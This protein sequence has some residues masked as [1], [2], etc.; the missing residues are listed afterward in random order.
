MN[1]FENQW[2]EVFRAGK[3]TDSL[4]R[5]HEFTSKDL[6][7]IVNSYDN[8]NHEAPV[9]IG[10]PKDNAPAFGWV[11]ELKTDGKTLFAKFKQLVPEFVDAVKQGLYKKRSI[12]LYPNLTLRHIGFLG[13][14]PPAVKGLAD[15]AFHENG[16]DIEFNEEKGEESMNLEGL[17]KEFEEKFGT[18]QKSNETL[19]EQN[20]EFSTKLEEVTKSNTDLVAKNEELAKKVQEFED[21]KN[22]KEGGEESEE[23]KKTNKKFNEELEKRD[24]QINEIKAQLETEKAENRKKEYTE[25]ANGLVEQGKAVADSV[26]N[27]ISI[28]VASE[29]AGTFSFSEEEK[30]LAVVEKIK[31]F[32]ENQPKIVEFGEQVKGQQKSQEKSAGEQLVDFANDKMSKKGMSFSDALIEAQEENPELAL[33]AE[34]EINQEL[35]N[36]A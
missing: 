33:K 32:L 14:V 22:V 2:V 30:D 12:S 13:A 17:K 25:F 15:I 28:L 31:S 35:N 9:V 18:L 23:T 27:I 36:L 19:V 21:K 20:K 5:E 8:K 34:D 16:I 6:E 29:K 10:H 7:T 1:Y 4:G 3:Q 26:N 24:K 11:E